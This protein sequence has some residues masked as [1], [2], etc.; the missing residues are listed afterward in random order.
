MSGLLAS[1]FTKDDWLLNSKVPNLMS[2]HWFSPMVREACSCVSCN[3]VR[4]SWDSV[5]GAKRAWILA[6]VASE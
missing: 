4:Y 3:R 2:P 1:E 6:Q 5:S